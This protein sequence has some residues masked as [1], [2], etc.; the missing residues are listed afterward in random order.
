MEE[1]EEHL[2]FDLFVAD[3]VIKVDR[4]DRRGLQ[5]AL[6]AF[7]C[8]DG[9]DDD[10]RSSSSRPSTH[11][12]QAQAPTCLGNKSVAEPSVG[13]SRQKSDRVV[14]TFLATASYSPT[15]SSPGGSK[16]HEDRSTN[17]SKRAG[18][19]DSEA[20]SIHII[21]VATSNDYLLARFQSH[22]QSPVLR[23]LRWAEHPSLRITGLAFSPCGSRLLCVTQDLT[24][25]VIATHDLLLGNM[26]L[27][28]ETE[29]VS[30]ASIVHRDVTRGHGAQTT[31]SSSQSGVIRIKPLGEHDIASVSHCLWWRP[32]VKGAATVKSGEDYAIISTLEGKVYF[33][34]LQSQTHTTYSITSPIKKL[35]LLQGPQIP[36][37]RTSSR[38]LIHT[39]DRRVFAMLL[40]ESLPSSSS[41]RLSFK[42]PSQMSSPLSSS[43]S[44][45]TETST[46]THDIAENGPIDPSST[47]PALSSAGLQQPYSICTAEPS[48][49][50]WQP[51]QI[52]WYTIP[53]T[54]FETHT[55]YVWSLFY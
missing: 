9:N 7:D 54:F 40:E 42:F 52:K 3:H 44:S 22:D 50:E 55:L 47:L 31:T 34:N 20:R 53:S 2:P 41:G 39:L 36:R 46:G 8:Q 23:A 11:P 28:K 21:A 32:L 24:L 43:S 17:K 12:E 27:E 48:R 15:P 19:D 30:L 6:L 35:E 33:I 10:C 49:K 4:N 5:S 1:D 37:S 38:L 25:Y 18:I 29:T 45:T 13:G 26:R 51:T 14:I 16:G